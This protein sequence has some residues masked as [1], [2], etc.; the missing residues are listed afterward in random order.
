MTRLLPGSHLGEDEAVLIGEGEAAALG[1]IVEH[2]RGVL[3]AGQ[4][5][6]VYWALALQEDER[7]EVFVRHHAVLDRVQVFPGALEVPLFEGAAHGLRESQLRVAVRVHLGHI[8]VQRLAFVPT[9]LLAGV[10]C[11]C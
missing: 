4:V 9:L 6:H 8:L 11:G 7:V 3:Q 1:H 2:S 5:Q 10:S